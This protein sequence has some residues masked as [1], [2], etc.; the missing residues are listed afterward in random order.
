MHLPTIIV[1]Q[2]VCVSLSCFKTCTRVRVNAHLHLHVD[3]QWLRVPSC[4]EA[5]LREENVCSSNQS[6]VAHSNLSLLRMSLFAIF[7]QLQPNILYHSTAGMVSPCEHNVHTHTL[8]V[9]SHTST[10]CRYPAEG[11]THVYL[12]DRS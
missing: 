6:D 2:D 12:S 8:T 1:E 3:T 7:S 10:V 5:C 11:V 9:S 4:P